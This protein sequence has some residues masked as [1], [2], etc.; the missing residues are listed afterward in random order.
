MNVQEKHWILKPLLI[1]LMRVLRRPVEITVELGITSSSRL[2]LQDRVKLL[3]ANT[4]L[5]GYL[6]LR[7]AC[8]DF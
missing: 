5:L 2:L 4:I 7:T 6:R 3:T 1:D 8:G